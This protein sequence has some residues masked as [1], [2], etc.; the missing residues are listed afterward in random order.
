MIVPRQYY[1]CMPGNVA[2]TM[3]KGWVTNQQQN[4]TTLCKIFRSWMMNFSCDDCCCGSASVTG[5][6]GEWSGADGRDSY[7]DGE[8]GPKLKNA[9]LKQQICLIFCELILFCNI[10]FLSLCVTKHICHE[11]HMLCR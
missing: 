3:I 4:N 9:S 8:D 10:G 11:R 2:Q 6:L 1:E 5:E 7:G